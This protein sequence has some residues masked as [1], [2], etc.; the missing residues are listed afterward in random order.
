[1]HR[2]SHG[3]LLAYFALAGVAV[4]LFSTITV[5]FWL[6]MIIMGLMMPMFGLIGA[7]FN[8]IAMEPL[9]KIAGTASSV[10]GFTQTVGGGLTGAA[11][12]QAY[13][14]TIV[15]IALGFLALSA[16]SLLFV[17]IAERGKLFGVGT[18]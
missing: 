18:Y 13:D 4:I 9:G 8:S 11:I 1:M 6:F 7:N 14:G 16:V 3:A 12:G 5:P 2:L 15:P 17:L 10:L